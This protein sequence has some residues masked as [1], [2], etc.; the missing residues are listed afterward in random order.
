MVLSKEVLERE[1]EASKKAIQ[2]HKEGMAIHTV[3]LSAFENA[4]DAINEAEEISG[5]LKE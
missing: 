4:L 2:A 1:I 5:K 3:V